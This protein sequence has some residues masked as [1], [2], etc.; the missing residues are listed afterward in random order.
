LGFGIQRGQPLIL[1]DILM[2]T[3]LEV[4]RTVRWCT[5]KCPVPRL[6]RRRTRRSREKAKA[7]RL[8]IIGLSSELTAPVA[9]GRQHNLWATRG[10]LQRSVGHTGPSDGHWTVS[11]APTEPKVQWSSAPDK[12]GDWE[13][14]SYCSCPVVH[15]TV[16]CATRQKARIAFQLDL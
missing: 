5:G 2:S 6:A 13:P 10:P 15:W 11:G 3:M 4:H 16:R 8:K 7:P 12:E 14:D 1:L 9:N